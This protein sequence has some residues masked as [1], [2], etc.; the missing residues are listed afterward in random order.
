[1]LEQKGTEQKERIL[2]TV[3][4]EEENKGQ[5]CSINTEVNRL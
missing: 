2:N 4:P 3:T 1:M 5:V